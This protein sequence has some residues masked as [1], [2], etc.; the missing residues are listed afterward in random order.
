MEALPNSSLQ[1]SKACQSSGCVLPHLKRQSSL[2]PWIWPSQLKRQTLRPPERA[3]PEITLAM[4][5]LPRT[6][7]ELSSPLSTEQAARILADAVE[8]KRLFRLT[9]GTANFEGVVESPQFHIQR[10]IVGNKSCLPQIR[11][12]IESAATGSCIAM[13]MTLPVI[14][15]VLLLIWFSGVAAAFVGLVALALRGRGHVGTLSVP[16]WAWTL[17]NMAMMMVPVVFAYFAHRLA[18]SVFLAQVSIAK[19]MLTD[20]FRA[21]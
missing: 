4:R 20:L 15:Q 7:L 8:P 5:L 6:K 21:R 14:S 16:L 9:A 10:L 11:G 2:S 3:P 1:L 19:R 13:E 12:R 17:G 18:N